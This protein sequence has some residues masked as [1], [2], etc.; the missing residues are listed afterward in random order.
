MKTKLTTLLLLVAV[1]AF[2]QNLTRPRI[3]NNGVV[4]D[5]N[6]P[7]L[8]DAAVA[9]LSPQNPNFL[10]N[11]VE[12]RKEKALSDGLLE[13]IRLAFKE[14][15]RSGTMTTAEATSIFVTINPVLDALDRGWL[16]ES[17]MICNN[18]TASAPFTAGRKTFLLN[19]IDA[20]I[21]LL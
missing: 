15:I 10:N 3:N 7:A 20:A 14:E 19:L 5:Y 12:Y 13:Q 16:R 9:S 17:R 8:H 1:T 18:T 2:S 4:T 6:T 21:A 11:A